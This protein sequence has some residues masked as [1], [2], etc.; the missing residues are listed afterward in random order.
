MNPPDNT[1]IRLM[2]E[3]S[4]T[5]SDSSSND[6]G[7]SAESRQA[8]NPHPPPE[9]RRRR[10]HL[11]SF[12]SEEL[13][14]RRSEER[15]CLVGF[16]LDIRKFSTEFVQR[17][18]N[19]EWEL[20]GAA[21]VLGRDDNRF[22]IHFEREIDRRV[23]VLANPWAIDGGI[24]VMQPWT[25]MF[26]SLR[27][28]SKGLT[29]VPLTPGCTLER[30]D[31]SNQWVRFRYER[32]QKFCL[33]CGEIGQTHRYCNS[34]FEEVE[35]RINLS[36]NRT[37]QRHN[38]PIVTEIDETHFS[39]Q[40]RAYLTR[41]SRRNTRIGYRQTQIQEEEQ[42]AR[43]ETQVENAEQVTQP[44]HENE[45][46][47]TTEQIELEDLPDATQPLEEIVPPIQRQRETASLGA[48]RDFTEVIPTFEESETEIF[49][50]NLDIRVANLREEF[51]HLTQR[52]RNQPSPLIE[53]EMGDGQ[54]PLSPIEDPVREFHHSVERTER[55][56]ARHE[57]GFQNQADYDD[58]MFSLAREQSHFE[59]ICQE[60]VRQSDY[61]LLGIQM[62]HLNTPYVQSCEPRWVNL[63]TG[64][65]TFTNAKLVQEEGRE[66][67]SSA[68]AERRAQEEETEYKE[69]VDLQLQLIMK[70][71]ESENFRL[72]GNSTYN[73]QM[74]D[75]SRNLH[76]ITEEGEEHE[77]PLREVGIEQNADEMQEATR[78]TYN[79]QRL[80]GERTGVKAGCPKTASHKPMNL[81]SWNVRVEKVRR[82]TRS[83]GFHHS[84]GS[85]SVGL[86]GGNLLLWNDSV[87]VTIMSFN[88]NVFL[89]YV[90][91]GKTKSW[92]TCIY[93][94]PELKSR[95]KVWNQLI[96]IRSNIPNN[97]E[98]I[99]VGDFNQVL[100]QSDKLSKTSTSLQG[101]ED[102]QQCLDYCNLSEVN[103]RGLHYT[104][105]NRRDPGICTWERLD[106]A[107]ANATWFQ[108]Y[109][110]VVLTN[111]PITIS[112]H[113]PMLLQ[114][115]RKEGFRKRP[116]RFKMM[117]S[118][119]P[120][121]EE[122]I[123]EG[124]NQQLVGSAA[125]KLVHK[126]KC[127]RDVLKRWNKTSFGNLFQ[128]KNKIEKEL[129]KVQ[130][131][132]DQP[133][134]ELEE[135]ELRRQL[136]EV[137]EQE[138]LLWM[139]KSKTNWIV[140][141]DRN[142]NFYH[143]LTKKRRARNRITSIKRRNGTTTED[144][145][146]IEHEFLEH[147]RKVFS[148]HGDANENIIREKLASIQIP[149]L[150]QEHKD[151]LNSPFSREE[152]RKAVFE[153][154][155][156]KAPGL[157]VKNLESVN[158]FRPISLCTVVYKIGSRVLVNRLKLCLQ[159]LIT[160]FQ[161]A[162][163]QGR[164]IHD[165]VAIGAEILDTVTKKKKGKGVI[166]L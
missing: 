129:E 26:H 10:S 164:N 142:T 60:I 61:M 15:E 82:L 155:P 124:W 69:L 23:G 48:I 90:D 38:L 35:R 98:W 158:D 131:S 105:S 13:E 29:Y 16:L 25:Q 52:H 11:F 135:K 95:K 150:A 109:E 78:E 50:R 137:M 112:D 136:E 34:S 162:F 93:G 130:Q 94:C 14:E 65:T 62:R 120:Q 166:A 2:R 145:C 5:D 45:Q 7:E 71:E 160:P 47:E 102:F 106:R 85:S 113:S 101:S 103:F 153:M 41:V 149:K 161:S 141:G 46:Q 107:F 87:K 89:L 140:K 125:Y 151:V 152:I 86:S 92:V 79:N 28:D 84:V 67:E 114:F 157:M 104:W 59:H 24:F 99:V 36:M 40:M 163:I 139:Q 148:N 115:N 147:F 66:A 33:N 121:C 4:W 58:M 76:T 72:I 100:Y 22:L 146:E 132:I 54:Y 118:L 133:R 8:N 12:S 27:Q 165:N 21:T 6:T 116:Y 63:P 9:L 20:R 77:A 97:E 108:I 42:N 138:Q 3:C 75:L 88:K 128:R 51:R 159:N 37:S 57:N 73:F 30:D 44:M 91:L 74:Q 53:A 18:I 56:F 143:T 144:L 55:I 1:R 31:G 96:Q 68:M 64:G 123:K 17:Y 117:W 110:H 122:V 80:T 83:W 154:G 119:N 127:T 49:N 134:S 32:I 70:A 19:H 111:L 43:R 39:N 126:L 156:F 81:I